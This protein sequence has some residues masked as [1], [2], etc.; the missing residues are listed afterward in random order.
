MKRES[1]VPVWVRAVSLWHTAVLIPISAA[2][3]VASEALFGE[4]VNLGMARIPIMLLAAA[5]AAMSLL[6]LVAGCRRSRETLRLALMTA[7]VLDM[8]VV[9]LLFF[10]TF[11]LDNSGLLGDFPVLAA[12]IVPFVALAIPGAAAV[13]ALR[14]K[15]RSTTGTVVT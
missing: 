11:Q 5:L 4:I 6:L 1:D 9:M 2:A 8:Q 10:F 12:P 15:S 3:Y 14:D 13:F 7:F